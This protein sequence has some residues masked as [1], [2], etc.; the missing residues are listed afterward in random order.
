MN[1]TLKYYEDNASSFIQNTLNKEMS[2]QYKSFEKYLKNK[3]HILDA[4][5]GSGRDS[6]YFKNKD[7]QVTSFDASKQM[8]DFAKELIK[9]EVM[10]LRFE[11]MCFNNKF[12]AIWASASLLHVPKAQ[13][14]EVL[15]KFAMALKPKGVLYTSFKLGDQEIIKEDRFFNSYTKEGFTKL[16]DNNPFTI[17]EMYILE[18]ARPDK[19]D[20][21]W[22]NVLLTVDKS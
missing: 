9:Q 18:D 8:C 15:Q 13:I 16:I 11:E 20:E 3:S 14:S 6:L 19:K 22:L 10:E 17:E 7:Y 21:F 1:S 4:G 5:C 2:I 12:D